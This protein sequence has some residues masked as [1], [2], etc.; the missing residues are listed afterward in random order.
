MVY[1]R[2][3]FKIDPNTPKDDYKKVYARVYR[4]H[5]QERV[6]EYNAS[7]YP[8]ELERIRNTKKQYID[9]MGGECVA[10]GLMFDGENAAVFDFHHLDPTQKE[11]NFA[12]R[13]RALASCKDELDKCV[14]LCANCHRLLHAGKIELPISS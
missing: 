14:V 3:D 7:R 11:F 8:K 5:N 13:N 9:Y 2:Q 1:N 4:L 6:R 10:C 12:G